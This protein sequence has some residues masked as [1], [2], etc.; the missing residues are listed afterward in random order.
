VPSNFAAG[1]LDIHGSSDQMMTSRWYDTNLIIGC[2][3]VWSTL[4]EFHGSSQSDLKLHISFITSNSNSAQVLPHHVRQRVTSNKS[5]RNTRRNPTAM[6]LPVH[7][8]NLHFLRKTYYICVLLPDTWG[9]L[10]SEQ[11]LIPSYL[12]FHFQNYYSYLKKH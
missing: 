9:W 1:H 11:K 10:N 4:Q 12:H 5:N 3:Q 2:P 7:E 8:L 6:N